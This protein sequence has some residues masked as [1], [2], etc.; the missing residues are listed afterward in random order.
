[1]PV[2]GV[3]ATGEPDWALLDNNSGEDIIA[4]VTQ[5]DR[6]GSHERALGL[7]DKGIIL[8]RRQLKDRWKKSRRGKIR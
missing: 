6:R 1:M 7:S 4:W 2:P 3:D 8:Y 5:G